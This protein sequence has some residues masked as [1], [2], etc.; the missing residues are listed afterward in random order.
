MAFA[1]K[2]R[3][4]GQGGRLLSSGG[5][6]SMVMAIVAREG[7][8]GRWSKSCRC[9]VGDGVVDEQEHEK[10]AAWMY[11]ASCCPQ[12]SSKQSTA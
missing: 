7:E 4:Q 5:S 1:W 9:L 3:Q 10:L 2:G 6:L 12:L 8:D 11:I